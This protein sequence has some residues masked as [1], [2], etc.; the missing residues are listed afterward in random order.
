MK[1]LIHTRSNDLQNSI[2][3]YERLDFKVISESGPVIVSDGKAFIEISESQY[4]R[5]GL[6][7]YNPDC[8]ATIAELKKLTTVKPDKNGHL[9]SDANGT[10]IYLS[11]EELGFD[12][13]P[14]EVSTS[15]L[16]NYMGICLETID[17][18]KS[19]RI[20]KALGFKQPSP[21]WPSFTSEHG[22]TVTL[23][24]PNNCPHLF[25]NPSLTYFNGKY[26]L[27]VIEKIRKLNIPITEEIT[28]F[29]DQGIVD[30]VVLRD[31]SG[32]GFLVFN[33]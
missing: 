27:N 31:P 19:S 33:D 3:Y 1:T 9:L 15:V 29:N 4:A 8:K 28:H 12:V 21:D 13:D 7:I 25:F 23:F 30:N 20:L 6:K 22:F 14:K 32:L 2:S 26:N 5:P 17:S 16:G 18:G 11:E 10:W 24:E